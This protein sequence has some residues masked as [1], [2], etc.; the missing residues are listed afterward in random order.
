ME[1]GLAG[2]PGEQSRVFGIGGTGEGGRSK[3]EGARGPGVLA[4]NFVPGEEGAP[5]GFGRGGNARYGA[6]DQVGAP[7]TRA[8]PSGSHS[9]Q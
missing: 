6:L 2:P 8:A 3:R 5:E 7:S 9:G 1:T 4:G